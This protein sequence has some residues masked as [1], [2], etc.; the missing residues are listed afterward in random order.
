MCSICRRADVPKNRASVN[1]PLLA[2]L[3]YRSHTGH[4]FVEFVGARPGE[5]PSGA[6]AFGRSRR[7]IKGVL[8]AAKVRVK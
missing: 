3:V 5:E 8:G 1:G 7:V 6:F 2:G 4:A